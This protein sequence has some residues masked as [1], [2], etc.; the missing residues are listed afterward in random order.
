MVLPGSGYDILTVSAKYE[1]EVIVMERMIRQ[2]NFTGSTSREPEEYEKLHAAVS[3]RAAAEGMVL[4][5]NEGHL[6]P[7][8]KGSRIALFGAGAS[9]TV[10][11]GTGSGDVNERESVN[12]W[13]G[14][15]DA[16]YEITTERWL[17]EYE[18]L[19][20]TRRLEWKA[21]IRRRST[22]A[23]SGGEGMDFWMAYSTTPFQIPA[24]PEV[25]TSDT[26]TA[27][28][29]LSR[30]S[31]ENIDRTAEAGDYFL[32]SDEHEMLRDLCEMYEK[33]L[34]ILNT[35]GVA[36]LSFMDE[37]PQIRAL[38]LVSQ[39]GQEGGH[40]VADVVSGAV[41]PSGKLTDSWAFRYEDYPNSAT[42]SHNNGNM[43]QEK[44]EEGIYVGYRYFD[45]FGVPVRYGFG[46]GLSYTQF[47][48]E[49]EGARVDRTGRITVSVK[50]TNCG[51]T[52]PGR[53]VV[54]TYVSLPEGRLEKER[55]R[56]CAFA[57]T[58]ELAPGESQRIEMTFEA[59]DMASY[60]ERRSS[61][62]LEPGCYGIFV[63]DS[64]DASVLQEALELSEEKILTVAEQICP[65]KEVLDE[66]SL[67][68]EERRMLYDEL[69][70]Q[71][72]GV[73]KI[74]YDLSGRQ[75]EYFRYD[76]TEPEDEAAE[77]VSGLTEDQLVQLAAG[78]PAKGQGSQLGSAGISVP[79]SAG[80]TSGCAKEEGIAEIILADGPAGLRLNQSYTVKEG[81][82]IPLPIEGAF[83]KGFLY[84]GPKAEGTEYYQYCTAFPIGTLLAQSWDEELAA[85]VG[86]AAG[87]EM[88]R[89]GITLWL[90]PGM[91]IHRNPLCGR[92]FEYYSEDPLVSG[93]IAAAV[94]KG[95]QSHPGCGTTIKH[96][97]CNNQED[98]RMNSDSILSERTLREIYLRGFGIAVR[99]AQPMSIMTSYNL[100]NGIHS[101][102]NYDLCTK[103]A[104]CEFGFKGVIMTD[105]CTTEV[106]DRCTASGCMRAGNDLVMPGQFSDQ[107]NIRRALADGTLS[108][109]QLRDCVT[110]LVRIVLRSNAYER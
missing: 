4:L 64:L 36:D 30:S 47:E 48:I 95:V 60:D 26:D 35:G 62:I 104:R 17:E 73:P 21:E 11:G 91:N 58:K 68:A 59:E 78:D 53:E 98:N 80:Q 1:Y 13:K 19:Y 2:R 8:R 57:K 33:V 103:A 83:E 93:R 15:K 32:S 76:Y 20:R 79:G 74:T 100:I 40:A 22:P 106:D 27:V 56:L 101:A 50:V 29:V 67:D 97:A 46:Y 14:L 18:E 6:L 63:G 43:E 70:L 85:E 72:S 86:S 77:L 87:D 94:T 31:G 7:I 54:Q 25:Y 66:L 82:I 89:F 75:T 92:N 37:F 110:R 102:N 99:E 107:E 5:K 39:P 23:E 90:A 52:F 41:V 105:W 12:I 108:E 42:F 71:I 55:R 65:P 69:A 84:D 10:K 51:D 38:L 3:R 49:T 9:R 81:E 16:G 28:Y 61:W 24:G 45:T 109:Q 88:E 44:Y 96:F 34:V